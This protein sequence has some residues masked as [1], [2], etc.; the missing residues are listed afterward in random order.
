MDA[1][2]NDGGPAY[3]VSTRSP[4]EG[5]QDSGSTW[6]YPGMSLRDHFAG[7]AM[8][9]LINATGEPL[10]RMAE[11]PEYAYAIADEMLKARRA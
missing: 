6:Q 8:Q 9:A 3:P 2:L 7:L 4:Q 11:V 5:H 1:H 10:D